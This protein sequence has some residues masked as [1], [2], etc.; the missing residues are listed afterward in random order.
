MAADD[1]QSRDLYKIRTNPTLLCIK[2]LVRRMLEF[3][4]RKDFFSNGTGKLSVSL[5]LK[6]KTS[7]AS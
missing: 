6:L 5:C 1:L 4:V 2:G 3:I 7:A